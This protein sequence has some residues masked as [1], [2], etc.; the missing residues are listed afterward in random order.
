MSGDASGLELQWIRDLTEENF[1]AV[2]ELAVV[3]AP[4]RPLGE[5]MGRVLILISRRTEIINH[6]SQKFA[7]R[8][9]SGM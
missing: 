8:Q 1:F 3:T 6:G 2:V 7:L 9:A 4:K 5:A